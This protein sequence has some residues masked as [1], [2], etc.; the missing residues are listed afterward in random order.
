MLLPFKL[1]LGARI[2]N[3]EQFMSWIHMEDLRDII[4]FIINNKEVAG[5]INITAPNPCTNKNFTQALAEA[6]G[7]FSFLYLQIF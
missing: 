2:G 4:D 1:C 3:G 5:P 7:K 6:L